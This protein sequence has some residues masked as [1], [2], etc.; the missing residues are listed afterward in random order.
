MWQTVSVKQVDEQKEWEEHEK[1]VESMRSAQE[2]EVVFALCSN[3][4]F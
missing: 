2:T 1:A 4:L 3:L